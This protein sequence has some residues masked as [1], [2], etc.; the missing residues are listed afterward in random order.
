MNNYAVRITSR[1]P[2]VFNRW[3]LLQ[4]LLLVFAVIAVYGQS[5]WFGYV[6]Y[7]DTLILDK[8]WIAYRELSW[9]GL[10]KIFIPQGMATYQP[11]RHLAFALVYRFS[12]TDPGGYHLF[13]MNANGRNQRRITFQKGEQTAPS[14]SPN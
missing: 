1:W 3:T 5:L 2:N 12:G 8:R 7:D 9:E 10:R 13:I 6:N 14:W 11:L 4:V